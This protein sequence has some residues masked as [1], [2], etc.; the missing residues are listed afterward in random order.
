ML[1][2]SIIS[3][4][5]IGLQTLIYPFILL[6]RLAAGKEDRKRWLERL[7]IY[8]HVIQPHNRNLIW[9]HGASVGE[10][11][12][13]LP[14]IEK[15][16]SN[17]PD[18][19]FLITSG[20]KTSAD[21]VA[22][23][24]IDHVTHVYLPWDHPIIIK[25]FL[26]IWHPKLVLWSESDFWPVITKMINDANIEMLLVNARLSEKSC[27]AWK[28]YAPAF[29][30]SILARFSTILAQT[31][32]DKLRLET[33]GAK[34]CFIAGNMKLASS[35]LTVDQAKCDEFKASIS[36]RPTLFFASTHEGEETLFA[37]LHDF[38]S[39]Q[40]PELL[41]IIAPRHPERGE[42]IARELS[43]SFKLKLRSKA[44]VPDN[45]T[46]IYLA[47]TLGELGLFYNLCPITIIGNSFISSPGGGHNPI[48]PAH[49]GCTIICGPSMFNF[50]EIVDSMKTQNA[51]IQVDDK[52][53]LA[54]VLK[55]CLDK[56]PDY[57]HI[58]DNAR[59]FVRENTGTLDTIYRYIEPY[60]TN[61]I[62]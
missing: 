24:A 51:L 13:L 5:Y 12:A 58:S 52:E 1:N 60:T 48:E 16:R 9:L 22:R 56:S 37:K 62:A 17:T 27:A 39:S 28:K 55:A 54:K 59:Q 20:T 29:I 18:T 40:C 14:L 10:V 49:F 26:E 43:G 11:N 19:H 7:A 15:I 23:R 36:E 42:A 4:L 8:N 2:N 21:L 53:H 31:E 35:A 46:Q 44:E 32:S 34:N 6:A 41:T 3:V 30:A 25:K 38:L 33:L 45:K 50:S 57:A 47:D 61:L